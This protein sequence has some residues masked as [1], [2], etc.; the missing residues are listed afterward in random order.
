[1]FRVITAALIGATWYQAGAAIAADEIP[2]DRAKRLV[3]EGVL[4]PINDL[5]DLV[6]VMLEPVAVE[7]V[8]GEVAIAV[9]A[10]PQPSEP[11]A[12]K[13]AP[14]PPRQRRKRAAAAAED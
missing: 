10:D 12:A 13:P 8:G 1:M 11:P 4:E 7:P 5:L 2:A 6:V 14:K 9:T 3:R